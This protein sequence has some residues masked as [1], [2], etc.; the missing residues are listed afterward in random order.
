MADFITSAAVS[1]LLRAS[2]QA[3]ARAALVDNTFTNIDDL[4]KITTPP[5]IGS[6]FYLSDVNKF[7]KFLGSTSPD[8]K[9]IN[10]VGLPDSQYDGIYVMY[11]SNFGATG[12]PLYSQ[13][14]IYLYYNNTPGRFEFRDGTNPLEASLL[15]YSANTAFSYPWANELV[16]QWFNSLGVSIPA[17]TFSDNHAASVFNWA[18]EL[19]EPV[20]QTDDYYVF[21]NG[22]W[23]PITV[24]FSD[25]PTLTTPTF[26]NNATVTSTGWSGVSITRGGVSSKSYVAFTTSGV[27][28]ST[29]PN[30][31][32]G[33]TNGTSDFTVATWNGA[34]LTPRM[35]LHTS[36][37]VSIG[38]T[39][40]AGANNLLVAGSGGFGTTSANVTSAILQVDSTTRGFLPP[41]M[42]TTQRNA[43]S[44]P[45][46]GLILYNS[47]TNTFNGR[48][49]IGWIDLFSSAASSITSSSLATAMTDETGG[50]SLVFSN[51]STLANTTINTATI[52]TATLN[53]CTILNKIFVNGSGILIE[54][55]S[56]VWDSL[57][58]ENTP[59]ASQDGLQG[60]VVGSRW[61]MLNGDIYICRDNTSSS[62]V[63]KKYARN[64]PLAVVE[65]FSDAANTISADGG[66][67]TVRKNSINDVYI[68]NN[69]V[70]ETLDI[71]SVGNASYINL[72]TLPLLKNLT[73][74]G[75]SNLKTLDLSNNID[76]AI[77]DLEDMVDLSTLLTPSVTNLTSLSITNA[78][79]LQLGTLDL[80]MSPSSKYPS[81]DVLLLDTIGNTA[82]NTF[83][84][85]QVPNATSVS[86]REITDMSF[87]GAFPDP[88]PV[89]TL[90]VDYCPLVTGLPFNKL[91]SLTSLTWK[92]RD[93]TDRQS[94]MSFDD[95]NLT[96][97]ATFDNRFSD[98]TSVNAIDLPTTLTNWNLG[99]SLLGSTTITMVGTSI[100]T[101]LTLD[102]AEVASTATFD[103][104]A[105]SAFNS[106]T[107]LSAIGAI[108]P[109]AVPSTAGLTENMASLLQLNLSNTSI[110]IDLSNNT[111][112]THLY[113]NNW[114]GNDLVNANSNPYTGSA[115]SLQYMTC[116]DSIG[117]TSL[118]IGNNPLLLHLNAANCSL[119]S[120]AVDA[121]LVDL[122][123]AGLSNGT[124]DISGGTNAAPTGG[125]SNPEVLSL[126]AKGWTVTHN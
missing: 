62:A 120:G 12:R 48:S 93:V 5:S 123:T 30:W 121:I 39:T 111:A 43:I 106:V 35:R 100:L 19:A 34:V 55:S 105:S 29:T 113:L 103:L 2:D 126:Q 65:G 75:L 38:T 72:D 84:I 110:E 116:Y 73:I 90:S 95:F 68:A 89:Q 83:N 87:Y 82:G 76:I 10:V 20:T 109:F 41:R 91:T 125:A 21:Q 124:L 16:G 47:T 64:T 27:L 14:D 102:N 33:V 96:S 115:A 17:L 15:A 8:Y 4:Y 7:V 61:H 70:C 22:Y 24:V 74:N 52:N 58:N 101:H 86:V 45:A 108:G 78:S 25:S 98:F 37:G 11:E 97:V 46:A 107:H 81:V 54:R 71:Q 49:N 1:D 51:G 66:S 40:D 104:P 50:G 79:F 3:E 44:S 6:E 42:T 36:G 99:G 77:I 63:W 31:E 13:G 122:D 80:G 26:V 56:V 28:N 59:T 85:V 67:F 94:I 114:A 119:T 112:L 69:Q 32:F 9:G 18:T 60:F 57:F 118:D 88:H 53:N 23:T 92:G 117:I